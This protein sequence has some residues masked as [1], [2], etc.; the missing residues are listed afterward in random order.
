MLEP[1]FGTAAIGRVVGEHIGH[2]AQ[3]EDAVGD[4][5]G[6]LVAIVQVPGDVF[7]ASYQDAHSGMH[8]HRKGRSTAHIFV[9]FLPDQSFKCLPHR[10]KGSICIDLKQCCH[11]M[12][13][14]R[15][16]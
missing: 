6:A 5:H 16:Q 1:V 3:A 11:V 8:L 7:C 12:T 4:E 14:F 13:V 9:V 2:S 15:E 10:R